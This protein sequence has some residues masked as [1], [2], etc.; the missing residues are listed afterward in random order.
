MLPSPKL[1]LLLLCAMMSALTVGC[2]SRAIDEQMAES[3]QAAFDMALAEVDAG[4]HESAVGLFDQA[5]TPG[6]GL[7][8]DLYTTARI[9]RA[10]CLARVGRYEDAH[11]DLDIASQGSVNLAVVHAC[12]SFV[13]RCEGKK[14]EADK[15]MATAKKID[16]RVKAVR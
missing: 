1:L 7:P 9:E 12:G 13:F 14:A 10:K 4:D 11:A 3:A 2:A 16:R 5:L 6:G 15:E 8:A